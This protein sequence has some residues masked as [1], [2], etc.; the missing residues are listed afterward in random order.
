MK[1]LISIEEIAMFMLALFGFYHLTF[2]WWVFWA[3]LLLPDVSMVGYLIG[4]KLG[5][6]LYN[7]VHH[8]A[9]AIAIYV[10]GFYLAVPTLQLAGI[11]LF[12]HSSMDRALDYGLKYFTG[13]KDTHL[14]KIGK[15]N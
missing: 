13:F 15:N 14:G 4:P 11:I 5:A 7:I 6:V 3:L 9:L 2:A 8:K 1:T 10:L 12:A